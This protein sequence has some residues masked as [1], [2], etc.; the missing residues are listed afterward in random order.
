MDRYPKV[1][2]MEFGP[3]SDHIHVIFYTH[4]RDDLYGIAID[5]MHTALVSELRPRGVVLGQVNANT[6]ENAF[7]LQHV[8]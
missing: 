5:A 1:L 6:V 3:S 7:S 2:F 8:N 4:D